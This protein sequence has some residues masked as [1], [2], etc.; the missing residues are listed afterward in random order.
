[1]ASSIVESNNGAKVQLLTLEDILNENK[2]P[3]GEAV[4]KLDC[5]GC[6]YDIILFTDESTLQK[7]SYVLIEYHYGYKNLKEKLENCGFT[8]SVTRPIYIPKFSLEHQGRLEPRI[9]GYIHA[10]KH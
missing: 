5:E 7:F 1:M 9:V 8:V 2:I 4:L 6:E 10:Q 3:S